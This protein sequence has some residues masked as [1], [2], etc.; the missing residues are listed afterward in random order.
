MSTSLKKENK[1]PVIKRPVIVGLT[2]GIGSGKSTVAK[3]FE[4]LNVPVF[5]SDLAAKSIL[6]NDA[7]VVSAIT[8]LFGNVYQ[9]GELDKV[10]MKTI[11]ISFY[12]NHF[13]AL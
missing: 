11:R 6:K 10:K 9:N 3:V 5:N 2:G 1:R 4:A 13:N 8:K 12:P 7:E